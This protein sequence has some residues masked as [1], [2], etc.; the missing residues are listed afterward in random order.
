MARLDNFLIGK[1]SGTIGNIAFR[2]VNGK[3]IVVQK[4]KSFIPGR[5]PISVGRR[6]RFGSLTRLSR[7]IYHIP[8]LNNLWRQAAP[9]GKS[10]FNFIQHTNLEVCKSGAI[11]DL[12]VLTP[13]MGFEISV[14]NFSIS[15]NSVAV[16]LDHIGNY[17]GI[18]LNSEPEA[19]LVVVL[20]MAD[21]SNTSPEKY[22]FA[23]Y[24]SGS[25]P[26]LLDDPMSFT[27]KLVGGDYSNVMSQTDAKVL[28][29]LLTL[30]HEG[31]IV[32]YSN[33]SR[34]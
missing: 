13:S 16:R 7:A 33:T 19:K 10:P 25:A 26:L 29:T 3:T 18:D 9:R 21:A 30:D 6:Q 31:I 24:I 27:A 12:A 28:I 20:C 23:A 1:L 5:D 2:Q 8:E 15:G 14:A 11:P 4:T 34:S 32:H 17:A 22:K